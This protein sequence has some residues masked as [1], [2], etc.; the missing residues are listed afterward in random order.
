MSAIDFPYSVGGGVEFGV[1]LLL[2]EVLADSP[3][4]YWPMNDASGLPQDASG[5]GNNMTAVSGSPTYGNPGPVLE[6]T[7]SYPST[8]Y[9][10][11]A[12][13]SVATTNITVEMWVYR[14]GN[15]SSD[16]FRHGT[17]SGGFEIEY[18]STAGAFRTN[19]PGV[20]TLGS[21]GTIDANTWTHIA[22]QR[23]ATTW[24]GYINGCVSNSSV[25][26]AS[27]GTPNGNSR[28]VGA[29]AT[30]HRFAHVAFYDSLLTP[31]RIATHYFAL[32]GVPGW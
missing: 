2:Q 11:R 4:A 28:V 32:V 19:L 8:A 7:I 30:E 9:H 13:V 25:G 3:V 26:S 24:V 27:P 20:G 5:N 29:G 1:D 31:Q 12:V 6:P 16:I 17:T 23:G 18:T 21:I 14:D 15:A 22:L 10:E